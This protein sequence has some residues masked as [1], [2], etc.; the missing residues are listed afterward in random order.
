MTAT[1]SDKSPLL[2]IVN[3]EQG[4]GFSQF[5][6]L[7]H[8]TPNPYANKDYV[9]D[10]WQ[11]FPADNAAIANVKAEN[12][13]WIRPWYND[14]SRLIWDE[15]QNIWRC[16]TITSSTAELNG[17]W[18]STW[19]EMASPDLC[20]FVNN[21]IPF[22]TKGME[23]PD[24]WG[25]S[26]V[27]D[28]HGVTP[29]GKGSVLYYLT[30][31]GVP[32]QTSSQ[33]STSL[34]V[35]PDLGM[36]PVFYDIVLEN[37]GA[38][39]IVHAP[40]MDFRD[41]RVDWDDDHKKFVM[42]LTV[43]YGITF[44]E[45]TDGI[46]WTNLST[47]D[48]SDWQQIETPDLVPMYTPDGIKKWVLFF[49]LKRWE[50]KDASSIGYMVGSWDGKTFHPDQ[51]TPK[52][53]NWGHDY[54]AQAISQHKGDTYCWAWMGCWTNGDLPTQGF[55]GNHSI[56]TKL[57]L[58]KDSDGTYGLRFNLMPKSINMYNNHTDDWSAPTL[59]AAGQQT[60]TPP[61]KAPGICWRVD[62]ELLRKDTTPL[63]DEIQFDFCRNG[64]T[65]TRL[66]LRPKDGTFYLDRSNSGL[67]P[68]NK[69]SQYT[70]DSWKAIQEGT[71]PKEAFYTVTVMF[72]VSTVE[73]IINNQ[74]YLSTLIFPPEDAFSMVLSAIGDGEVVLRRATMRY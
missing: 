69:G 20:N 43:G 27:I 70:Q 13:P 26:I 1:W 72:D 28:E 74:S 3:I 25:G 53:V 42:K 49:S 24:L 48:L 45:S 58:D 15:K 55:A 17:D 47:I 60:W 29:F 30:M 50:G 31:P 39:D 35:A 19:M 62:L 41:P 51:N 21:R 63:P 61:L 8:I 44:Y 67:T 57:T 32:G 71:L 40:G 16:F 2:D 14:P 64:A 46:S 11:T 54:Y 52:R 66:A 38:G 18:H 73:I 65:Y 23:Y 10:Y 34:W 6:P 68:L 56:I 9:G 33:Q 5:R 37:P 4:L 59:S 7:L 12:T 36:T 22:Y